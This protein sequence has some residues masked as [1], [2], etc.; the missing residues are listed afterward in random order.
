MS[1]IC[2]KSMSFLHKKVADEGKGVPNCN[3]N[4]EIFD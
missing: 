1:S 2:A 4:T 3:D